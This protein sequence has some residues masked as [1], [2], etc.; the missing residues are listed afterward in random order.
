MRKRNEK[1]EI[2][3]YKVRLVAQSFSQ[4]PGIDFDETYAPIMDII[5]FRYLISLTVSEG[6]DLCLMDVV[7]A[8]LYGNLDTEI[9]MKLSEGYKLPEAKSVNSRG[10]YSIKLQRSLY[11]LKQSG[12]M[13]YNRLSEYLKKEGYVNDPICPCVFIKRSESGFAIVAVYVDDMNLIVTPEKLSKTAEY[14]KKRI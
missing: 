3:R 5:T 4:R 10:L 9:Y 11:G 7:T 2:A 13:W 8:Y 1:N 6:L 12:R 14:L